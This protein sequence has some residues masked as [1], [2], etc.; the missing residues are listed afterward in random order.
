MSENYQRSIRSFVKRTGRLTV[1]QKQA[2]EH[3]WPVLGIDFDSAAEMGFQ[4][5][6]PDLVTIKLE[7]GFGN[8]ETLVEMAANDP[9]SGYIGIEVHEP[10][11][12]HCLNKIDQAGLSNI[13]VMKHDAIEVLRYMVPKHSLDAV[14]LFFPDPWHKKRH[15]KRRIVNDE[16]KSLLCKVMKP[17]AVLHMATDW[18]DYAEHMSSEMIADQRFRSLGDDVGYCEKPDYRPVTKFER[19]GHRLGHGVWDL[20]FEKI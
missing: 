4:D 10:G 8:G 7:I 6:F 11:V 19:R 9:A 15:H 17:G 2:L 12:G 3:R 16:F 18:Q 5:L 1:G 20:R 13:R 14:F